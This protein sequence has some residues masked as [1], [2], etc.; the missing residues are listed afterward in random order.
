[1]LKRFLIVSKKLKTPLLALLMI[2]VT[3]C[4]SVTAVSD[5]CLIADPSTMTIEQLSVY[6]CLCAE[7]PIDP[8]C[9]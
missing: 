4:E 5:Y 8:V 7:K 9:R 2:C 3:S 6:D 1:M